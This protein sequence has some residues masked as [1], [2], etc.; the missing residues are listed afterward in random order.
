MDI[1]WSVESCSLQ[2]ECPHCGHLEDDEWESLDNDQ[3][4][5]VRC[6]NC[7]HTFHIGIAECTVCGNE[8]VF[9]WASRPM[10]DWMSRQRC[11]GCSRPLHDHE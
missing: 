10:S 1:S 11:T 3:L 4:H 6:A 9:S 2:V 5:Q 8:S 7:G